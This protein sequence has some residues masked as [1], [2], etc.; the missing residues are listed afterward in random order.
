M[1]KGKSG[2]L[3][4]LGG[5]GLWG[6]FPIYFKALEAVPALEVLAHRIVGSVVLL[7]LVLWA[8]GVWSAALTELRGWRKAGYYLL[9][10]VLIS[11]NWLV[12]I[13]AIQHERV[14]EAS[15]GYY[16]N[17]LVNVLLG[18]LFLGERLRPA[19]NWRWR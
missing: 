12:Y 19:S 13:W 4:A 17:P 7:A 3:Y 6:L 8:I 10:T 5:F 9:T 2:I 14:L 18:V 15:L 16:I 1:D 11:G